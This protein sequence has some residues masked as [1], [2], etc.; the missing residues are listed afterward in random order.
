MRLATALNYDMK[1]QIRHG[2]YAVYALITM[3]YFGALANVPAVVKPTLVTL[4]IFMDTSVL[5]FFFI[6]G[7]ILL[8]RRQRTIESLFVT[9]L[10]PWEYLWAK[11]ISLTILAALASHLILI[12]VAD[13]SLNILW[14]TFGICT[15]SIFFVFMGI[16]IA[17]R[18]RTINGYFFRGIIYTLVLAVPLVQF[19]HLVE[20][21]I[22]SLLPTWPLL[23]LTDAQFHSHAL[24]E[25]LEACALLIFWCGFG[26]W[27]AQNWFE[28]YAI[29]RFGAGI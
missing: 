22:I 13:M 6:G 1:F 3:F 14:F 23:V 17:V 26:W 28:K 24:P 20:N 21:P 8:E 10:R 12:V 4:L 9:P 15:S 7:I 2:F 29:Q 27:W 5:G 25:M 19:F 11:V 18:S 16:A